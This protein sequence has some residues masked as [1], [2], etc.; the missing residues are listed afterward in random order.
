[1]KTLFQQNTRQLNPI[2]LIAFMVMTMLSR[3]FLPPLFSCPDNFAPIDATALFAGAYFGRKWIAFLLPLLSVWF[4]DLYVNYIYYH[5]LVLFYP[6]FYWQYG[7]YV[8]AV[9]FG[10]N[11]LT[12]KLMLRVPMGAVLVSIAFFLVSNFGVWISYTTYPHT[13]SGLILCYEAGIPYF[14]STLLSDLA[15]S[16]VLFGTLALI[17]VNAPYFS[18]AS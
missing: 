5:H 1:M 12:K 2:I 10:S 11:F 8:L 9:L 6:G 4:S 18:K 13:I 16:G 15:Y 7:F 14:R 17:K 3:F